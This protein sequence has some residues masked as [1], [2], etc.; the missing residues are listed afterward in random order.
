MNTIDFDN[1][2]SSAELLAKL[3][4][5]FAQIRISIVKNLANAW[6]IH[7]HVLEIISHQ[8]TK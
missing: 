2:L 8:A 4:P 3:V 1:G 7:I 6:L 5:T